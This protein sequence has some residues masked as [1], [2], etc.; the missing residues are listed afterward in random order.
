MKLVLAML[1]L[2]AAVVAAPLPQG[3]YK[4][5]GKLFTNCSCLGALSSLPSWTYRF[6][7]RDYHTINTT[8]H[9]LLTLAPTSMVLDY[10]G[11]RLTLN[12]LISHPR[13][14]VTAR[15]T[16]SILRRRLLLEAHLPLLHHHQPVAMESTGHMAATEPTRTKL[17]SAVRIESRWTGRAVA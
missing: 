4:D 16:V 15:T 7:R 3:T 17:S 5:Y 6:W 1:A 12:R 10:L 8:L 14:A 2:A 9:V 11:T 13:Q